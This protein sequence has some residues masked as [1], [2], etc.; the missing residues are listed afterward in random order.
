MKTT[1]SNDTDETLRNALRTWSVTTPLP[2]H[3]QEGVWRRIARAEEPVSVSAWELCQA[4]L[5]RLT[6]RPAFALAYVS[7]ALLTGLLA[8][9]LHAQ[10]RREKAEAGWRER[11]VESVDPW[12][13]P[14]AS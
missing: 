7:L 9:Y 3:F 5:E 11:Y 8:G 10:H 13:A 4:W 2:P 12:Q 14:H 1:P 6:P